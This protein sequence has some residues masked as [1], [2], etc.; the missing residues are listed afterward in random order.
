[1]ASSIE[2]L[3]RTIVALGVLAPGEI[4]SLWKA[5]P[6]LD[7]PADA[8]SFA[9][10][11]VERGALTDYQAARLLGGEGE[12]LVLGD[13][14][15]LSKLGA[16][17]MGEVYKARHRH[18]DRLVAIK[19]L[20]SSLTRDESL[21]RRFQREVRA[22][23]KLS[24]PN[25]VAAL[26]ARQERGSWCL[27]MEYVAG[28][29]LSAVLRERGPLPVAEALGYVLQA[30]RGL[31]YAHGHGVIHRDV[32]PGN[33]LVD[34]H[35]TVKIIDMGLAR[36]D[37]VG[38]AAERQLTTTGQV[39][40]TVDYMAPEQ[41]AGT[42]ATDARS[43]IYSLGCTLYA[44][45]VGE[46]MFGGETPVQ[47][48]FAHVHEPIP[49]LRERRPDVP[50]AIEL[51]FRRMV[52]KKPEDRQ[53][54]AD[55]LVLALEACLPL[56]GM[57]GGGSSGSTPAAVRAR[58]DGNGAAGG[59]TTPEAATESFAAAEPTVSR[60]SA[61]VDTDPAAGSPG[62]AAG[63]RGSSDQ[64]PA[65][66]AWAVGAILVTACLVAATLGVWSFVDSD[67]GP[68]A[69][70]P[71]L[72]AAAVTPVG[73]AAS[74]TA[75]PA[76]A[77]PAVVLAGDA[78]PPPLA[79]APF[80]ARQAR[81]HQEAWAK[82][83]G[84]EVE[85][86]NRVG[87]RMI[88]IP[89]GEFLMGSSDADV[90]AA[91]RLM[92]EL[93]EPIR[94]EGVNSPRAE[95]PQHK[96]VI[97][98]P[99]LMSAT[100]VT[101]GQYKTFVDAT[102]YVTKTEE[103]GFGNHSAR[104]AAEVDPKTFEHEK[105]KQWRR[106]GYPAIDD[107]PVT[108][109]TWDD[110]RAFCE[111]MSPRENRIYRLPSEAE[112]EYA[113]R[114]GTTTQ[115]SF[116]DGAEAL[117]TFGW[118]DQNRGDSPRVVGESAANPF[119]LF[120]MHGNVAEW[121]DDFFDYGPNWSMWYEQMP[122]KDPRTPGSFRHGG[123]A[124]LRGLHS[125]DQR[126]ATYSRSAD[127]GRTAAWCRRW[128]YGFRCMAEL[129]VGLKRF[130]AE[131]APVPPAAD[132]SR[133]VPAPKAS[134][135]A[136][137]PPGWEPGPPLQGLPGIVAN[138]TVVPGI[139][140]WQVVTRLPA[141]PVLSLDYSPRGKLAVASEDSLVRIYDAASMRLEH[142]L[143]PHHAR[144]M[145]RDARND[146]PG[147][148]VAFS[149]DGAWLATAG[150]DGVRFWN[151]ETGTLSAPAATPGRRHDITWNPSGD[152]VAVARGDAQFGGVV[153]V[154]APASSERPEV[155][156]R[157]NQAGDKDGFFTGVSW[158][159]D[160][161]RLACVGRPLHVEPS[162]PTGVIV[163]GSD[164][165]FIGE[166]PE[167]NDATPQARNISVA[168]SPDGALI[169]V[170]TDRGEVRIIP[171]AGGESTTIAAVGYP[172]R[173][174]RWHP[175]GERL[176]VNG[177]G[178]IYVVDAVNR[179]K[180]PILWGGWHVPGSGGLAISR[181]SHD[182]TRCAVGGHGSHDSLTILRCD[183]LAVEYRSG[184]PTRKISFV[185]HVRWTADG[186]LV[187]ID[188]AKS[189]L[190]RGLSADGA[191]VTGPWM[192]DVRPDGVSGS[193]A[194]H[195]TDGS[196]LAISDWNATAIVTTD[197]A[198]R[199][200]LA[201]PGNQRPL[202]AA[203]IPDGSRL[204][205]A[206]DGTAAVR[207]FDS[208]GLPTGTI[209]LTA[210]PVQ[211]AGRLPFATTGGS[212]EWVIA[213]D[214]GQE[215]VATLFR[216]DAAG[217]VA[218]PRAIQ[219]ELKGCTRIEFDSS[220]CWV[221]GLP[222]ENNG[223]RI[224]ASRLADGASR[225]FTGHTWQ[226]GDIAWSPRNLE[227]ISAGHDGRCVA[228]NPQSD[229]SR[230]F[231]LPD[232]VFVSASADPVTGTVAVKTGAAVVHGLSGETLMPRWSFTPLPD[233]ASAT[234]SAGGALISGDEAAVEKHLAYVVDRDDGRRE[235]LTH[236]EFVALVGQALRR[237]DPPSGR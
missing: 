90:E 79:V 68:A 106:P 131:A 166:M 37:A 219:P 111:W 152:L 202:S 8:G 1:M 18:M 207:L 97:S 117:R 171:S 158:S 2:D 198:R 165:K 136:V 133:R 182:G 80:D 56:A 184:V 227:I 205:V 57:I 20:A 125:G 39:I 169:A 156:A 185:S 199:N 60:L 13:Y 129:P 196:L 86:T 188:A 81:A 201:I 145:W 72:E 130:N 116:G 180:K 77:T 217:T 14:V 183:D 192:T 88:L 208:F 44:L 59:A 118:F 63:A 114:A 73:D 164:G 40:G 108:Q 91:I 170:G 12:S 119:G 225:T 204:A 95:Q 190:V 9:A 172:A 38:D 110:A 134:G 157:W 232:E 206:G 231:E 109:I 70:R 163:L 195:P 122:L 212:N 104:S 46:R 10:V 55:E 197:G 96:V 162:R 228:W 210:S 123:H 161:S 17:G 35:G 84:I 7:R 191:V 187:V 139:S 34:G 220:G 179:D 3:H 237:G 153:L 103:F 26:D 150:W 115:Y 23:A 126:L 65:G 67:R 148:I 42:G 222:S 71:P 173:S 211:I 221:A 69:P 52:A 127:R 94:S 47:R 6:S 121:C 120:D 236:A 230:V 89:P 66:R 224:V 43:D 218:N 92:A 16:G 76:A 141:T 27:V 235:I 31:A 78:G 107:H 149:P 41:A 176:F 102:G 105:G 143:D 167:V 50:E 213:A 24:H 112:W 87:Q 160:G 85:T 93:K 186:H 11:L 226:V 181:I 155:I 53:Q 21:V 200:V 25:I 98:K 215:H 45:L 64:R 146:S 138:P 49:S 82:H 177:D 5:L 142:V 203:W 140:R 124:V 128:S 132:T 19:V 101:V 30:A 83:L 189:T 32:K 209:K 22:A 147:C 4:E 51:I 74:P 229:E 29:D 168:W 216:V 214:V 144:G 61:H 223:V 234:F 178:R 174:L 62:E 99:F 151:A 113:C 135:A 194:P 28:R 58:G 233:G 154:K 137:T 15:V 175:D 36:I 75:M 159:P 100:E 33:L 48:I 193:L 54:S